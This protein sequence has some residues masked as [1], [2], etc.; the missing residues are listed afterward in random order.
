MKKISF[1]ILLL[2]LPALIFAGVIQVSEV[3]TLNSA[4]K[5]IHMGD[6]LYLKV[7]GLQYLDSLFPGRKASDL[8]L[9]LDCTPVAGCYPLIVTSAAYSANEK[10]DNCLV[11]E[12]RR[13]SIA[14]KT[15]KVY[16]QG[17]R[18]AEKKM[19]ISTGFPDT[20]P[21]ESKATHT[22]KL[23]SRS[24]MHSGI[25]GFFVFLLLFII[26][27][28][29]TEILRDISVQP[30]A[31]KPFSLART[32]IAAW[33][34]VIVAAFVFIWIVSGG[35]PELNATSLILLGISIA[36]T[37]AAGVIDSNQIEKGSR[38]Q[39]NP[40]RGFLLDIISDGKGVSIHRFQ[41]VLWTLIL[42][43]YYISY[44]FLHLELPNFSDNLL[45][46]LGISNGTYL[47]LKIPES[48]S[49]KN[50]NQPV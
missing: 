18:V 15:L 40:S 1:S 35:L 38:P 27:S 34:L 13:D 45:I 19:T 2:L 33:T 9:F 50:S 22:V 46:L 47:G 21:F 29:K 41:N 16:Y 32:Q 30:L 11:F 17:Q 20:G 37:A 3:Q 6:H 44:T 31:S 23:Y 36:T 5:K 25:A 7:E 26:L 49:G 8:V 24:F 39:D 4:H 48:T 42:I 43:I 14:M 10:C 28:K 12:L